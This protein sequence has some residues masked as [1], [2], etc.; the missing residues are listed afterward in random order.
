MHCRCPNERNFCQKSCRFSITLSFQEW[1]QPEVKY[2]YLKTRRCVC[3]FEA[4]GGWCCHELYEA[5]LKVRGL[6]HKC[7]HHYCGI[8][9]GHQGFCCTQHFMYQQQS[10]DSYIPPEIQI[11]GPS[12]KFF[13]S[14][15][16][17]S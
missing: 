15:H 17:Q 8:S 1:K 2:I 4:G 16:M 12:W 13:S 10:E 11:S 14:L 3:W 9:I 7:L 5:G 6:L